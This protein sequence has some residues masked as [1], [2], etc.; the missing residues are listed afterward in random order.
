MSILIKIIWIS[1]SIK[2]IFE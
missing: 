1:D 2:L